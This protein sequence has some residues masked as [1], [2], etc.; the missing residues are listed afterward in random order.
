[1]GRLSRTLL[2]EHIFKII[3]MSDQRHDEDAAEYIS[4]YFDC[5]T[6]DDDNFI[7][8]DD[9][10]KEYI[11]GKVLNILEK[12]EE[13]DKMISDS[14]KGWALHRIARAELAILRVAVYEMLYDEDIPENVAINEAIELS[15]KYGESAAPSFINGI[16][17]TIK[18][19]AV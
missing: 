5:L 8:L 1:M 12:S 2:R 17:G 16:L 15:K 9:K 11:S 18:S 7:E 14:S 10:D 3:F 6:D 19:Q 13:I 4:I